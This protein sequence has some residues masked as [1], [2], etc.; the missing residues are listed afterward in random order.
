MDF[1]KN[2]LDEDSSQI[3]YRAVRW[4]ITFNRDPTKHYSN[5]SA[6]RKPPFTVL[7]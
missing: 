3:R 5:A 6:K 4:K 7:K 1:L 2:V